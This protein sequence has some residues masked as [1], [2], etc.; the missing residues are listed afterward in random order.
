MTI[1]LIIC[2][3]LGIGMFHNKYDKTGYI[4]NRDVILF[5]LA[6][7]CV[8]PLVILPFLSKIINLNKVIIKK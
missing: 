8:L 1:F 5:L 3:I 2:Y 6:P 7:L 4:D